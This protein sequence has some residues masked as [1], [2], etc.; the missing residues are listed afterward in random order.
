MDD[1]PVPKP[2]RGPQT[3][4]DRA[5][6]YL[7]DKWF[8]TSAK[9]LNELE[10]ILEKSNG[11]INHED[12]LSCVQHDHGLTLFCYKELCSEDSCAYSTLSPFDE[13]AAAP[14]ERLHK[15]LRDALPALR[16]HSLE[17]AQDCQIDRFKEALLALVT[18]KTLC[19]HAEIDPDLG[20]D[21]SLFRQLG[22]LLIA[23]NYP[24]IYQRA[25]AQV[26]ETESL[27]DN[28]V[29]ALGFSPHTLAV[30]L[31]Q[32][33][34]LGGI[35]QETVQ[36]NEQEPLLAPGEVSGVAQSISKLCSVGEK[37]ARANNPDLYPSALHDWDDAKKAIQETLGAKGLAVID[38]AMVAECE[39]LFLNSPFIFKAGSLL[40]LEE[41]LLDL[42]SKRIAQRNP[43]LASCGDELQSQL[44][45][46]YELIAA[47]ERAER[48]VNELLRKIL[49]SAGFSASALFTLEPG[50]KRLALQLKAGEIKLRKGT[51]LQEISHKGLQ[52]IVPL[53]FHSPDVLSQS[54]KSKD[55][56]EIP[57]PSCL[58]TFFGCSQR[59]GVFYVE[60]P[61]GS[62]HQNRTSFHDRLRA[63]AFALNDCLE[64]V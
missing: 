45:G 44:L 28:L 64:L 30:S 5:C 9:V 18:T 37:L 61:T 16:L 19:E 13:I 23:W 8:P 39:D 46:L 62:Y 31:A 51:N 1:K 40:D 58:A 52:D 17:G 2:I 50:T 26:S 27:D 48:T 3:R 42:E 41:K 4:L 56:Q 49:P 33:W 34:G 47:G 11:Q 35:F 15:I 12:L 38:Q 43:H 7:E 6:S 22:F 36:Y 24:S 20:A 32:R 53:A 10:S 14:P 57:A 29:K 21:V 59:F 25:V 54:I 63:L 60:L 55:P